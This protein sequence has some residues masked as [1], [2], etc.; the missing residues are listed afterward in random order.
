MDIIAKFMLTRENTFFRFTSTTFIF[1]RGK[2]AISHLVFD[3]GKSAAI[4]FHLSVL[5]VTLNNN[6]SQQTVNQLEINFGHNNY[7]EILALLLA[8]FITSSSITKNNERNS[9]TR[10]KNLLPDTTIIRTKLMEQTSELL[11]QAQIFQT[12]HETEIGKLLNTQLIVNISNPILRSERINSSNCLLIT[13]QPVNQQTS[14]QHSMTQINNITHEPISTTEGSSQSGGFTQ[15]RHREIE[16][17]KLTNNTHEPP[18]VMEGV[19]TI[20]RV[21]SKVLYEI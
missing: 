11:P 8:R 20:R 14:I 2:D 3:R 4:I 16:Y 18:T 21:H 6:L 9:N 7:L 5:P 19:L 13:G 1:D 17:M 10:Q 15:M 12:L